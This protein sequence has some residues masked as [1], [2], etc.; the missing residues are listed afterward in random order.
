MIFVGTGK[1]NGYVPQRVVDAL[2]NKVPAPVQNKEQL[3]FCVTVPLKACGVGVLCSD[4]RI[5]IR[6]EML[7]KRKYPLICKNRRVV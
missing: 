3:V 5:R 4:V 1:E 6:L 2:H 7:L